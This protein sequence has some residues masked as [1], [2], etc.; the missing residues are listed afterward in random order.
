M[1]DMEA[2]LAVNELRR[3][4]GGPQA[5]ITGGGIVPLCGNV[6]VCVC[7]SCVVRVWFRTLNAFVSVLLKVLFVAHVCNTA[8][9][10]HLS[11]VAQSILN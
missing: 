10:S 4:Q 2:I 7:G 8:V 5:A 11:L 1:S 6:H 3:I 9:P